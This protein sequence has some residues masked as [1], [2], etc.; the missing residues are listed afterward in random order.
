MIRLMCCSLVSRQVSCCC[1]QQH[2][3]K[4]NPNGPVHSHL[5]KLRHGHLCCYTWAQPDKT[6]TNLAPKAAAR[7]L[8]HVPAA[9]LPRN[10]VCNASSCRPCLELWLDRPEPTC[11]SCRAP[12]KRE[13][14][15]TVLLCSAGAHLVC[16]PGIASAC[17][18][19]C[20]DHCTGLACLHLEK[21]ADEVYTSCPL[22]DG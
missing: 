7:E 19:C 3:S 10:A 6:I 13:A 1:S 16:I 17:C 2:V 5:Q 9:A 22:A 21:C 8:T 11:P 12:I 18:L 4:C 15:S 14:S 20:V